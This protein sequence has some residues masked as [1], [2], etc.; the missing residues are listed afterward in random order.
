MDLIGVILIISISWFIS[1]GEIENRKAALDACTQIAKLSPKE[2]EREKE[3]CIN[4]Y[5]KINNQEWM[6]KR[7]DMQK[8]IELLSK[9]ERERESIIEKDFVII[10]K[11]FQFVKQCTISL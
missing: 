3:R 8:R 5:G 4:T 7:F 2:R 9:E 11:I 1:N 6:C 10:I